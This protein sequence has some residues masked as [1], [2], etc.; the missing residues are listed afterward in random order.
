MTDIPTIFA[1]PRCP[2]TQTLTALHPSS[3]L[4]RALLSFLKQWQEIRGIPLLSTQANHKK[5]KQAL[6]PPQ[7]LLG[8]RKQKRKNKSPIFTFPRPHIF[9]LPLLIGREEKDVRPEAEEGESALQPC[10][11]GGSEPSP[12]EKLRQKT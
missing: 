6:Q 7:F 9:P 8:G 4:S 5:L 1:Y 11:G 3:P 12:G 2:K 10:S